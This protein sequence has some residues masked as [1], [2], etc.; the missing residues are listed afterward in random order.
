MRPAPGPHDPSAQQGLP[1][2]PDTTKRPRISWGAVRCHPRQQPSTGRRSKH[3]PR[4]ASRLGA[5]P[6]SDCESGARWDAP[7]EINQASQY[8][9]IVSDKAIGQGR[10]GNSNRHPGRRRPGA[11]AANARAAQLQKNLPILPLRSEPLGRAR[12]ARTVRNTAWAACIGPAAAS[13]LP[14]LL[15]RLPDGE[16][17]AVRPERPGICSAART[18][19]MHGG[20]PE[21]W[22]SRCG[23]VWW[24]GSR[25]RYHKLLRQALDY[26]EAQHALQESVRRRW[27]RKKQRPRHNPALLRLEKRRESA[28]RSPHEPTD[29]FTVNL[30]EQNLRLKISDC[31]WSEQGTRDFATLRRALSAVDKQGWSRI[32]TS[33]RGPGAARAARRHRTQ[34][35]GCRR[36]SARPSLAVL[37][38]REDLVV[39]PQHGVEPH[40]Q[41]GRPD[42][43]AR[44]LVP[45][46]I[47]GRDM[48]DQVGAVL[49][50]LR[51][52]GALV[53]A[54]ILRPRLQTPRRN[55]RPASSSAERRTPR[56]PCSRASAV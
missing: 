12:Q 35:R 10:N 3:G 1:S 55:T 39:P 25:T 32:E 50:Q 31:F 19:N 11:A 45:L 20:M 56:P 41:G 18:A 7:R 9:Q 27:S 52:N 29:P 2:G 30:A 33:L 28:L 5:T 6:A 21:S 48:L 46:R 26:H 49:G 47:V 14:E 13:S 42:I 17:A 34:R 23:R 40:G 36:R 53:R 15:R 16:L 37:R 54:T 51:A 8:E 4:R 24:R 44:I 43:R 22:T 38:A